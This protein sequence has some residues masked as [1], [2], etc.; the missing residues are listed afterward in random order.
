M[1]ETLHLL[2][3]AVLLS[4]PFVLA[5]HPHLYYAATLENVDGQIEAAHWECATGV[6]L[7]GL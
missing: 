4:C 1:T 3:L 7:R 2:A 5:F 6:D